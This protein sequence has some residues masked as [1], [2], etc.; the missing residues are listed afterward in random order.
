MLHSKGRHETSPISCECQPTS[1]GGDWES[2]G[3]DDESYMLVLEEA[4]GPSTMARSSRSEQRIFVLKQNRCAQK[5]VL[6]QGVIGAT[7]FKCD[8]GVKV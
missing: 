1:R 8:K 4:L 5:T 3:E 7:C 2:D 6:N